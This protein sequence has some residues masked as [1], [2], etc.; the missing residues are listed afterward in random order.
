MAQFALTMPL[1]EGAPAE[2]LRAAQGSFFARFPSGGAIE[3]D[4][5]RVLGDAL[6]NGDFNWGLGGASLPFAAA[7]IDGT[8]KQGGISLKIDGETGSKSVGGSLQLAFPGAAVSG[9]LSTRRSASGSF[10]DAADDSAV[11]LVL[12]G[13]AREL[14][15]SPLG[16]AS[17][18]N[19]V[20]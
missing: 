20:R 14:I 8:V 16:N 1:T 19:H 15:F 13:T 4:M 17:L 9:S 12:S 10:A 18:S 11:Q 6:V 2:D 5:A 3:G 7:T